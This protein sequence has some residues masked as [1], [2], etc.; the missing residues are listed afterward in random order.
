[1]SIE[2]RGAG[3]VNVRNSSA[4]RGLCETI[5]TPIVDSSDLQLH[6]L[7]R[8]QPLQDGA[9]PARE[10]DTAEAGV[11][12]DEAVERVA[13]PRFLGGVFEPLEGRRFID[14]PAIAID[15]ATQ[16]RS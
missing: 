3:N 6:S 11:R 13:R 10:P 8:P 12:D 16:A 7:G 2:E 14:C 5:K 1:M 4:G 9:V 15:D